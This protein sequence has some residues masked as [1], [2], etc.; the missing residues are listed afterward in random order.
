VTL[1]SIAS[2]AVFTFLELYWPPQLDPSAGLDRIASFAGVDIISLIRAM[3]APSIRF[4]WIV[5]ISTVIFAVVT[6]LVSLI[7]GLIETFRVNRRL[8]VLRRDMDEDI[9]LNIARWRTAFLRTAIP[10]RADAIVSG[11][12]SLDELSELWLD[13]LTLGKAISPLPLLLILFAG[14]FAL[15]RHDIPGEW[16]I[17][18]AAG[19]AAAFLIRFAQYLVQSALSVSIAPSV[20][21]AIVAIC[22]L[23]DRQS[24]KAQTAPAISEPVSPPPSPLAPVPG[25]I[26]TRIE[27]LNAFA[28]GKAVASVLME[29]L[30]R[31]TEAADRFST[32]AVG[33]EQE[34]NAAL[35]E[36]RAKI[37]RSLAEPYKHE[38]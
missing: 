5:S 26:A 13:R 32:A 29:P 25:D 27:Q 3:S 9:A 37:E 7:A 31:L 1:G 21:N 6:L 10:D 35:A 28:L 11:K 19:T 22:A 20:R 8:A 33:R 16:E 18:L 17:T 36:V 30:N 23:T 38:D 2:A 24:I 14:T 34:I 12:G 4:T 15:I